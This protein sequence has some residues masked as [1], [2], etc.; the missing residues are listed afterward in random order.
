MGRWE[1]KVWNWFCGRLARSRKLLIACILLAVLQSLTMPPTAWL[2]KRIVD[3]AIPS[4]DV[5]LMILLGFCIVLCNIASTGLAF[6]TRFLSLR[7]TKTAIGAM[8]QLLLQR[9]FELP[10]S[11]HDTLDRG[12]LHT[13]LVQDTQLVDVMTNALI[14]GLIPSALISI[15]LIGLLAA[16]NI[17]LLG[18]LIFIGPLLYMVNFRLK[19]VTMA[20]AARA[21][22][23]F[24]HFSTGVHFVLQKLDLARYQSAES[25]EMRRQGG[26]I[27][28]QRLDS[29]RMAWLQSAYG[30]VQNSIVTISGI[31][32][33]VIGGMQVV[34]GKT[35][36]G[37]LLSFYVI[38]AMLG[39]NLQQLFGAVPHIITGNQSLCALYSFYS[40]NTKP[41]YSGTTQLQFSGAIELS[42]VSFQYKSRDV[43]RD[44]SL[45]LD[46]RSVTAI[47]GPN[48]G[49]KTTVARLIL[50][51]YRPNEGKLLADGIPYDKLDMEQ[52]RQNT[53]FTPQDPVLF[54]GTIWDNVSYGMLESDAEHVA[55]ACQIALVDDFVRFLPNGYDTEVGEDG[56]SLSGGQRQKIAIA[57]ALARRPHLLILD[58]PTNHLD[59]LSARQMLRNL[60]AMPDRPT[61]LI[62]T[63][64][65]AIAREAQ[66]RYRLESGLLTLQEGTSHPEA[67]T[68][69]ADLR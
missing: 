60:K 52:L 63:Q 42:S 43:F 46:R 18:V 4:R 33:L 35:S 34:S 55:H 49:G 15:L 50:G 30:L 57:R 3:V 24:S 41:P 62:I 28:R 20:S 53:A 64:D 31:F 10:R 61:L 47:M 51:L 1:W 40:L 39:S 65:D 56:N 67:E 48:G 36:L 44:I 69:L 13:L 26:H 17:K 6:G 54:R 22:D 12:H 16:L 14:S 25:A 5:H 68:F 8:R 59:Q 21:R 11:V 37:S 38:F 45:R 58:E 66:V 7:T 29:E 27:E 32:I 9:C 19:T 23:S 2:I